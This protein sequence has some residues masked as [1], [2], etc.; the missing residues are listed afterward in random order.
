MAQPVPIEPAD[1]ELSFFV[2]TKYLE[3]PIPPEEIRLKFEGLSSFAAAVASVHPVNPSSNP[4][5]G[6]KFSLITLYSMLF[7]KMV[8][9]ICFCPKT[10]KEREIKR[11][12]TRKRLKLFFMIFEFIINI[13]FYI[14][15]EKKNLI[16]YFI[17]ILRL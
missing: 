7:T 15:L 12:K 8:S 11:E 5:F 14:L 2:P 6:I 9:P 17:M 3:L 16:V 4:G 1:I 13:L 10:D